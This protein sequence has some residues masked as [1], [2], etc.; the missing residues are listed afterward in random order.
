MLVVFVSQSLFQGGDS[1]TEKVLIQLVLDIQSATRQLI[2]HQT[3][4]FKKDGNYKLVDVSNE[5]VDVCQ[6]I[7]SEFNQLEHRGEF[8]VPH[9][10]SP[11][12]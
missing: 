12:A 6:H 3:N 7:I 11:A 9:A 8:L 5:N 4:W 1:P 2:R 10:M